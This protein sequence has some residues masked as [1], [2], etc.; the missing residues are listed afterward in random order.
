MRSQSEKKAAQKA[1]QVKYRAGNK[2]AQRKCLEKRKSEAE[3]E[4]DSIIK[5]TAI[6]DSAMRAIKE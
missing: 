2:M 5:L 1:A 6:Y 4:R 3:M